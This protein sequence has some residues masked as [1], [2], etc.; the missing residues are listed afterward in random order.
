MLKEVTK[1]R[2]RL[3]YYNKNNMQTKKES[4]EILEGKY[5]WKTWGNKDK[6]VR[7][8]RASKDS[9]T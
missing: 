1:E 5:K 4:E 9:K 3:L 8:E 2:N 7:Q 6:E